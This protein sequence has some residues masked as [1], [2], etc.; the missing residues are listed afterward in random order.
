[1]AAAG[2]G[3]KGCGLW[4]FFFFFFLSGR[5]GGGRE[6]VFILALQPE[7]VLKDRSGLA[8]GTPDCVIHSLRRTNTRRFAAAEVHLKVDGVEE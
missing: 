4:V 7:P 3:T 8:G 5:G 6:R 1:M 2:V